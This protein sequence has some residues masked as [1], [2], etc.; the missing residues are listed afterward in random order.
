MGGQ[1]GEINNPYY[2]GFN[3]KEKNFNFKK[4]IPHGLYLSD[5]LVADLC[6]A[7]KKDSFKVKDYNFI[8]GGLL[9]KNKQGY[10]YISIE[11]MQERGFIDSTLKSKGD[12]C[13]YVNA[14]Y[15][16]MSKIEKYESNTIVYSIQEINEALVE[17]EALQ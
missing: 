13:L 8:G 5:I 14:T 10:L 3:F 7:G 4:D 16:K 17:Y 15:E 6:S 9:E 12:I 2:I 1:I 11:K